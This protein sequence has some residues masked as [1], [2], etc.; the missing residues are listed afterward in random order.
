MALAMNLANG[1]KPVVRKGA[2]LEALTNHRP[3]VLSGVF[4]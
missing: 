3:N 1:I 2:K 4:A